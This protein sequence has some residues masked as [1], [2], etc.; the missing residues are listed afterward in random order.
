MLSNVK[1][2]TIAP[3]IKSTVALSTL[4]YT[5]EYNIYPRLV[6][7]G[8]DHKTVNHGQGEYARSGGRGWMSVK[9]MSTRWKDSGHY[10]VPG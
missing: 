8:Y 2:T 1:Q 10:Y 5:D 6:E 4:I 3:V 9:F 7:W